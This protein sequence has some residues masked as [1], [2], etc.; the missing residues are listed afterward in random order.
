MLHKILDIL[1]H[2]Y[3]YITS[4]HTACLMSNRCA[5]STCFSF[6]VSQRSISCWTE[7]RLGYFLRWMPVL[8]SSRRCYLYNVWYFILHTSN[9]HRP[10]YTRISADSHLSFCSVELYCGNWTGNSHRD[11]VLVIHVYCIMYIEK[12]FVTYLYYIGSFE[13]MIFDNRMMCKWQEDVDA[14]LKTKP[15]HFLFSLVAYKTTE[16][17]IQGCTNFSTM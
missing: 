5:S 2:K 8:P 16:T 10:A 11:S 14:Y 15:E 17:L 3:K 9:S 6:L 13:R 1:F 12:L 7:H 4:F